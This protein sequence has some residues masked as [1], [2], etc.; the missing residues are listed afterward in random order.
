MKKKK[1]KSR[2]R[3]R[4]AHL[5]HVHLLVSQV[6][7]CKLINVPRLKSM[8]FTICLYQDKICSHLLCFHNHQ[9]YACVC[10]FIFQAIQD[11]YKLGFLLW[12]ILCDL[13]SIQSYHLCVFHFA[14]WCPFNKSIQFAFGLFLANNNVIIWN[15]G[16]LFSW[17]LFKYNSFFF[18]Y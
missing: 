6:D 16:D 13:V 14:W 7:V 3:W 9:R 4:R 10:C 8:V 17:K 18:S 15:P 2:K 5:R 1:L 12:Q 11:C